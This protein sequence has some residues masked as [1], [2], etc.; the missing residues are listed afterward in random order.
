VVAAF[1]QDV[2][3]HVDRGGVFKE[4]A[5]CLH[6]APTGQG[7]SNDDRDDVRLDEGGDLPEQGRGG[8]FVGVE[9][10]DQLLP[11]VQGQLGRD[12]DV[13]DD[14]EGRVSQLER[15]LVLELGVDALF[16]VGQGRRR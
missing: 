16:D 15:A 14:V 2:Q 8:V 12:G 11:G 3:H 9:T 13:V 6:H 7:M 4:S 5:V 10:A 1:G